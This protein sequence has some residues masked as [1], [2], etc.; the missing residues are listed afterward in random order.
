MTNLK[1]GISVAAV[2]VAVGLTGMGT[3]LA[4]C[5]DGQ[6]AYYT[7][8]VDPITLLPI[9]DEHCRRVYDVN[10]GVAYTGDPSSHL[11][12]VLTDHDSDPLTPDVPL[13]IDGKPI[14][15]GGYSSGDHQHNDAIVNGINGVAVGDGAMVGEWVPAS[16]HDNDP[17]TP[18]LPGHYKYVDGGTAIGANAKVTHQGSTALGAGA[19]STDTDQVTLGTEKDTVRAPGITSQKSK[20]RQVGPLEVV[21]TDSQGRLASDGG[22]IYNRLGSLEGVTG[23]HGSQLNAHSALLS[24]HSARLDEHAKGLAIAMAMPDT[25]LGEKD[26]FAIAGNLGGFSDETAIGFAAIARIDQTWSLNAG[27]GSDTEFEEFG[28][29]IGARAGW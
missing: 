10:G 1:N 13:V 6:Q 23:S 16:D 25:W 8:G 27:V 26:R 18:D 24:Q 28:W 7:Q 15:T 29:K 19:K 20:D 21:T 4:A 17:L 12:P 3:A 2:I 11:T 5:P 22:E 9:A 14:V